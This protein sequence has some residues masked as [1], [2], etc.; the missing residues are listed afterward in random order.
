[1]LRL[2]DGT[3]QIRK[4]DRWEDVPSGTTSGAITAIGLACVAI[5]YFTTSWPQWARI[6]ALA[7][8]LVP[9]ALILVAIAWERLRTAMRQN[10]GTEPSRD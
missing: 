2:R 4:K 10:N 3:I 6:T 7:V 8:V 1:M 9:P 5:K